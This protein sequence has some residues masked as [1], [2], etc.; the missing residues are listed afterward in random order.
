MLLH[1][2]HACLQLWRILLQ[3]EMVLSFVSEPSEFVDIVFITL[4]FFIRAHD[5]NVEKCT[6]PCMCLYR[7]DMLW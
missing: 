1:P 3:M 4:F 5:I 6:Y 7:G 2:S